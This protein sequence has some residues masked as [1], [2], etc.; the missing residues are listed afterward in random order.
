M[1]KIKGK[2]MR[3][4]LIVS[5]FI[6]SVIGTCLAETTNKKTENYSEKVH[7]LSQ[8]KNYSQAINSYVEGFKNNDEKLK[9]DDPTGQG[10]LFLMLMADPKEL[11]TDA[12]EIRS[13]MHL[14]TGQNE[15]ALSVINLAID[16]SPN[17]CMP[18][19]QRG[20]IYLNMAEPAKSQQDIQK[21]KSLG[22]EISPD[23]IKELEEKGYAI[24]NS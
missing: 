14:L 18:Y 1:R 4:L 9:E 20:R 10:F 2:R 13:N 24:E 16:R 6:F 19:I 3:I 7:S 22:C 17:E 8:E 12:L 15:E 5:I 23:L 21:A 11:N